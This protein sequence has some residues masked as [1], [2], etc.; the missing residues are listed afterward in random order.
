MENNK[1]KIYFRA[2][3]NATMGLGHVIRSLALAE[4]SNDIFDCHFIIRNP[5]ETLETQ[6]LEVC[7]S[8]LKL[9]DTIDDLAEATSLAG[10][11]QAGDVI[12]L[13]GYHFKKSYQQVFKNRGLKVVCIDDIHESHFVADAIINHAGGL[14]KWDYSFEKYTK[15]FLGVEYALVRKPFREAAK[16]K[17]EKPNNLF[18]C[19]GGADPE[20]HTL[21]V[22]QKVEKTGEENTCYLVLGAAYLHQAELSKFLENTTLSVE[23]LNNLSADDM[24]YYMNKCARAVTP[25]STIAYEYLST[26]GALFLKVIADNQININKYFLEESLALSFEEDFGRYDDKAI[27]NFLGQQPNLFDGNQKK[28]FRNIFYRLTTAARLAKPTDCRMYFD[29]ANDPLTRQQS[30]NSEPIIYE[31]HERWFKERLQDDH[32]ILYVI[33][34]NRQPI[35]Q[36]R[37]Q[38]NQNEAVISYSLDNHY[39]GKGLGLWIL[40]NGISA[41][42]KNY[43]DYKIIGFVKFENIASAKVFRNL[44]FREVVATELKNSYKY[45]Y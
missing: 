9:P 41:F 16:H 23:L 27:A 24:V 11:L 14:K 19:L 5:L 18:I 10:R 33:E 21:E 40:K 6:I 37:F 15:L 45:I 30:Y 4:M 7:T 38:L 31:N 29:W 39:R 35:G 28:R 22:L 3:G 25:P 43:S 17:V 32:S 44:K 20:N 36:V 13:D 26:G 34:F 42:R 8:I 1:P 2:D 12:V